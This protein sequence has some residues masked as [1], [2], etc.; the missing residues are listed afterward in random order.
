MART[1]ASKTYSTF[2]A[3]LMTEATPLNYPANTVLDTLNCVFEREGNIKRRL[4]IDYEASATLT[5]KSTAEATW[6]TKYSSILCRH[7]RQFFK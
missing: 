3:G 7:V 5:S 1:S 4:G 6:Q 2:V